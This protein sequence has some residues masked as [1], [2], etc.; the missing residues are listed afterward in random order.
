MWSPRDG[1]IVDLALHLLVD[2]AIRWDVE[3]FV[4]VSP[5]ES[6]PSLQDGYRTGAV[7]S[8]SGR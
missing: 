3:V 1:T 5:T 2:P 4:G 7:S 8:L 6:P